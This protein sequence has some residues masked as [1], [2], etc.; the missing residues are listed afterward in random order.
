MEALWGLNL[1]PKADRESGSEL[2]NNSRAL[3]N[4]RRRERRYFPFS[5]EKF[6]GKSLLL[7]DFFQAGKQ[8]LSH[9]LLSFE[10]EVFA[11]GQ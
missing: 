4:G 5:D 7:E 3:F 8:G 9:H 1:L 11:V 10:G 6:P 2:P